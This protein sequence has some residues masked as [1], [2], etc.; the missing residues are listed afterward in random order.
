MSDERQLGLWGLG[1]PQELK[2][3]YKPE[4]WQQPR[5]V[6]HCWRCGAA[7]EVASPR[8][9]VGDHLVLRKHSCRFSDE[10]VTIRRLRAD[11]LMLALR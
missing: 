8:Q 9:V 5:Y 2:R 3:D 6:W 11:E 1:V 7:G 10:K 4:L